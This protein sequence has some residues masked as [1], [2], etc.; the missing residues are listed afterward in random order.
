MSLNENQLFC[1]YFCLLSKKVIYTSSCFMID[2]D[3][4]NVNKIFLLETYFRNGERQ[5]K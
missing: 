1:E 4:N 5:V 2:M 3:F